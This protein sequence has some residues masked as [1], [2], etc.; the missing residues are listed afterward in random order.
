MF[1]APGPAPTWDGIY[2]AIDE[3]IRCPQI[4]GEARIV[5]QEDCLIVNVYT[6]IYA[7]DGNLLP[8]MVWIHGGGFKEGSSSRLLYGADF[9]VAHDVILVTFNYRLGVQGFLCLG[10]KEAPGN[11]G[12]KDQ[13]AALKWV[14]QNIRAF[15]GNPDDV[16]IFGE[17]AGGASVSYHLVSP[18]SRGLFHKAIIQS[19]SSTAS[20]ARQ[21][22][23]QRI[24]TDLAK[25]LGHDTEDPYQIYK[26][27]MKE[28]LSKLVAATLPEVK[29]QLKFMHLPYV[30]C[31]E[32]RIEGVEPFITDTPYNILSS[33]NY[34]KVPVIIGSNNNE[35]YFF[36]SFEDEE[37][38][39]SI[40]F[41]KTL[42]A[43]LDFPSESERKAAA[44]QVKNLYMGEDAIS[45]RNIVKMSKLHGEPFFNYP[46]LFETE[47]MLE[48]SNKPVYSYEFEHDGWRNFPK[49]IS[50]PKFWLAK[51]ASHAD[52]LFY[53]FSMPFVPTLFETNMI[54]TMTTLW[55]NFAKY[56]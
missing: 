24:A 51:G 29:G 15:G 18:M 22:K 11:A 27:L 16:T 38:L 55:T 45:W 36:A 52:D 56:G 20:W 53:L 37:S 50:G 42:P 17:S 4:Y 21:I 32:S 2:E 19:G 9:L 33:G 39:R 3:H 14:Q 46:A 48:N 5:G 41:E 25:A 13:V 44:L 47:L 49:L 8:V 28:D 23:P 6:P 10:I 40:Q 30:P 31:T 34:N 1:Q 54:N 12:M 43:D 35:G 26:I 7:D